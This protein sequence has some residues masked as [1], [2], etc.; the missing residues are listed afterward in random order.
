MRFCPQCK[1]RFD[2]PWLSF[3]SDDGTPLIQEL[4]PPIDPNWDPFIREPKRETKVDTPSEQET[5]WLPRQPPMPG[6]WI[7][8]DERPSMNPAVWQPPPPPYRPTNARPSQ[9]LA[10]ASMITAIAGI[11]FGMWCFGPLPGIAAVI[12]GL[13]ALSQIKKT[14]EKVSGKPFA[15]AGVIIGGI[16]ITFYLVLFLWFL[17]ALIFG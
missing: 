8:P 1:R 13:I 6:G 9:G 2:E 4:T 15:V 3:C 12:M 10:L 17:L 14:P 16:T 11:V 7:P 5:Q